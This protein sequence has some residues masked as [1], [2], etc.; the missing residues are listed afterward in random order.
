MVFLGLAE[1]LSSGCTGLFRLRACRWWAYYLSACCR[2]ARLTKW[3]HYVLAG[4]RVSGAEHKQCRKEQEQEQEQRRTG[5]K[6]RER[7]ESE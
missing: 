2:S 5:R 7:G 3:M 6:R 1:G 4:V